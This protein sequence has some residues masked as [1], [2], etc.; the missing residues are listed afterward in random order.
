MIT[1]PITYQLSGA[2]CII[3]ATSGDIEPF[4]PGDTIRQIERA[5]IRTWMEH[6]K[7]YLG[8]ERR[9]LDYGSGKQP[10]RDLVQGDYNAYER[11]DLPPVGEFDVVICNQVIQYQ[12]YPSEMLRDIRQHISPGG[13]LLITYHGNWDVVEDD[14]FWRMTPKGM[15]WL[16]HSLGFVVVST[17]LRAQVQVGKF[18]FPI[19]YGTIA[20][21]AI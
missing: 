6:Q 20:R 17:D 14:D 5:S 1:L 8:R 2:G 9:V 4:Y 12:R 3:G 15:E 11:D 19:G 16:L 13:Y 10:Y 21:R 7:H 18:R